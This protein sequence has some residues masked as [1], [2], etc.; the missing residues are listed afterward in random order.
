MATIVLKQGADPLQVAEDLRKAG[1]TKGQMLQDGKMVAYINR[2]KWLCGLYP[3]LIPLYEEDRAFWKSVR[4]RNRQGEEVDSAEIYAHSK[5]FNQRFD[6]IMK[7]Y[8]KE[9]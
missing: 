7:K 3:E 2:R 8:E 5:Y 6:E 9:S 4:K 1:I